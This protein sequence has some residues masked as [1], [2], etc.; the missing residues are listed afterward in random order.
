M[1]FPWQRD[2]DVARGLAEARRQAAR[3]E[4]LL[5]SER[6]HVI[7]PLSELRKRNHVAEAITVLIQQGGTEGN[8]EP[9]TD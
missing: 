7:I 4:T 6:E 9:A 2:R 3:A 1:R 5:A 8:A